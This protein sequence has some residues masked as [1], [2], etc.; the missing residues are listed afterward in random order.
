M[1]LPAPAVENEPLTS[2]NKAK[3]R[4]MSSL[5][6]QDWATM[7]LI[8]EEAPEYF[9]GVRVVANRYVPGKFLKGQRGVVT[10]LDVQTG[11][12]KFYVYVVWDNVDGMLP[13]MRVVKISARKMWKYVT[14]MTKD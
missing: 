12:D 9:V 3:G 13:P 6:N 7:S 11:P 14:P 8:L 10:D 2:S 5:M 4:C 1:P